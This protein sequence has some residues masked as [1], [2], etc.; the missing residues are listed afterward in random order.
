ME[1]TDMYAYVETGGKQYKVEAG[2]SIK[3]E[4]LD[5]EPGAEVTLDK[6]L[7]V[8]K[9]DGPV[10]GTPYVENAAVS[11][12]VLSTDKEKKVLVF[13]QKTRKNHRKLRGHRQS[14]TTLKIKEIQGV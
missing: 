8:I 10:F 9:E 12:E 4:K 1:E 6:V 2:Q 5:V 3:V 7:A 13:K 11:A 14:M